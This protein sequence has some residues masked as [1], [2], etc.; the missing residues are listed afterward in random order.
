VFTQSDDPHALCLLP[1]DE[2]GAAL[3]TQHLLGLGRKRIAHITGPER[4]EAVRLRHRGYDGALRRAGLKEQPGDYLP[5]V[6]SEAWGR[7]AVAQLF[8]RVEPPD[9]L[10][11][12]NDQI[13]RGALEALRERGISVPG[14]VAVVGFDNWE[15]MSLAARPPLSSIDMNLN[16]LGRQAGEAL[17]GMI[18]GNRRLSGIRRLPCTLVVRASSESPSEQ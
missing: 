15:V 16:E 5:G 9:G 1:D 4:F 13:A 14:E 12:G 3:A 2:G 11:C 6:W 18:G 8:D 10:F 17:L 7:D